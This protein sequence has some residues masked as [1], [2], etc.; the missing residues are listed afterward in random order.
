MHQG[1]WRTENKSMEDNERLGRGEGR[2]KW[3]W[4]KLIRGEEW[5]LN[6]QTWEGPS[7]EGTWDVG[8]PHVGCRPHFSYLLSEKWG[9]RWKKEPNICEIRDSIRYTGNTVH[10][11]VMTP[12]FHSYFHTCFQ[13]GRLA[14]WEKQVILE[15]RLVKNN[16]ILVP[17][18]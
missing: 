11:F 6:K 2:D 7:T 1:R 8:T 3:G 15:K 5:Q 13:R 18:F 14:C 4:V 10:K 16:F 9:S 12:I 17:P